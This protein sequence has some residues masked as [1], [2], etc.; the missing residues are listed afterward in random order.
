MLTGR[1][2]TGRAVIIGA[3][4]M[5]GGIAAQLANAGWQVWLLDVADSGAEDRKGRNAAAQAGLA[6]VIGSK[7]PLLFLPEYAARIH[8]GNV[9]DDLSVL[10]DADWIVEAVVENMDVK[11]ATLAQIEAHSGPDTLVSSN[12]SGLSLRDMTAE[13][14]PEFRARFLGTHFLNPPRYLKLL[15][16]VTLLDTMSEN[17]SGILIYNPPEVLSSFQEF[18]EQVL[19][20]RVIVAE[21]TPGFISTR[22]WIAHLMDTIHTALEFG[23]DVET[24]DYLTGAFVGRPRSATFRMA[25]LVGL[26][27]IANIARNQYDSLPD[28]SLRERLKLPDAVSKLIAQN[29]LGDK[30]GAGFYR[31]DG[32]NILALDWE[33]G[34]YRPRRE[35]QIADVERLS[36]LPLAE[37]LREL[38]ATPADAQADWQRFVNRVLNTFSSYAA[39][40]GST[41][42]RDWWPLDRVM[43]WGFG[44]EL[45]PFAI[46]KC[47]ISPSLR[48]F[49]LQTKRSWWEEPEYITLADWKAAGKTVCRSA[50]GSLVDLDHG[51]ACL[52]FH[53]KL[54]TLDPGLV[55]WIN[56]ARERAERDFKALVIGNQ[57]A[58][59]SAGY[60]LSLLI[61]GIDAQDWQRLDTLMRDVQMAFTALKYAPIPIVAAPHGYTLGGGCECALHCAALQAAP[62]LVMGLPEAGVGLV[63]TGGGMKE[64]LARAM[65]DWKPGEDAFPR[66]E[67]AFDLLA[68]PNNSLNAHHA[69]QMGLLRS[70]D[71]IS[72]N[73][74]RQLYQAKE[75]AWELANAGY[76]PP[77]EQNI[78][79]MGE[80]TLARL[81]FKIHQWWRSGLFTDHDRFIA[82]QIAYV[83]SGGN[84]PYPQ[85]VRE[86]YLLDLERE[87]FLYLAHEPKTAERIRHILATGKPLKN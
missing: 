47:R 7:P 35:V 54:N 59:F 30:T 24:V 23:L 58:H 3:G 4:T 82:D 45:G 14:S 55:E 16:V 67:R 40:I 75:R 52:E 22:L 9:E 39:H 81:R 8:V 69:R 19:G 5:G 46:H 34:N 36:R 17:K 18:A 25:D 56:T 11:K 71:G 21:D 10:G 41:I 13:C 12:T 57:A 79:I 61:A 60:N 27:I 29:R 65:A 2:V 64:L 66:I 26:D 37:R 15:E 33:T 68:L 84:L 62:E 32:K 70:V 85:Q 76:A 42:A 72:R 20:Q 49:G 80:E 43:Q 53:T 73:A 83:L 87:A 74:D 28:D 63:P 48:E 51:V 78:W 31:K 44:W 86:S 38:G 6:R 77:V 50:S 1:S